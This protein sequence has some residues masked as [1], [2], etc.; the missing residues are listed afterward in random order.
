VPMDQREGRGRPTHSCPRSS[1]QRHSRTV[2]R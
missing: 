1:A 2:P